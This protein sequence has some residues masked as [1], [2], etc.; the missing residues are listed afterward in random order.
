MET[1]KPGP[2]IRRDPVFISERETESRSSKESPIPA[3]EAADFAAFSR[4]G[5]R[6]VQAAAR[7]TAQSAAAAAAAFSAAERLRKIPPA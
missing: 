3:R 4:S 5:A 6:Q 2:D 7:R 1:E